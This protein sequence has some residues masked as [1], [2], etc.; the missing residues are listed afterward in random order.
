[1]ALLDKGLPGT[2]IGCNDKPLHHQQSPNET[3]RAR[4]LLETIRLNV[5]IRESMAP[6]AA[7]SARA[8]FADS[9]GA[10]K[11]FVNVARVLTDAFWFSAVR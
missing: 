11:L 9:C 4:R 10:L 8:W 3:G 1:M 2:C 5:Q 6:I 7:L